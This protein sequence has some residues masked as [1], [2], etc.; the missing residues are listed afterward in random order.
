MSKQ[1]GT[2]IDVDGIRFVSDCGPKDEV[3]LLEPDGI[4]GWYGMGGLSMRREDTPR[5]HGHGSIFAPGYRPAKAIS[6]RGSIIAKNARRRREMSLMLEGILADGET[7]LMSVTSPEMRSTTAM[8]G[9]SLGAAVKPPFEDSRT[10]PFQIGFWGPDGY[11]NGKLR[12]FPR[13]SVPIRLT[14]KGKIATSFLV[15]VYGP[16]P[17]GYTVSYGSQQ[18][19]VTTG[20][21][22]GSVDI[23]DTQS[24][25]S[26]RNGNLIQNGVIRRDQMMVRANK[27][28]SLLSVAGTGGTGT[29][30][31]ELYDRYA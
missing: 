21:N 11:L 23:H 18:I 7:G 26:I 28:T 8:V 22:A 30:S 6:L 24:G 14:Q 9:L 4:T 27:A 17:N 29:W 1:A 3:F 31:A 12:T 15:A 2:Q 20:L 16:F 25:M 5:P 10:A 13:G 19:V